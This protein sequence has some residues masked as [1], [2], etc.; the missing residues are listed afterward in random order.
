MYRYNV[1]IV[2]IALLMLFGLV[3]YS[4]A[5]GSSTN[6]EVVVYSVKKVEFDWL[7]DAAG[8]A[9]ST[10]TEYYT[11]FIQRVVFVP[12]AGGTQPT[13]LYDVVINDS[14]GEDVLIANGANLSNA[15]TV[16]KDNTTDGLGAVVASA[17][18]LGVTNAGNAKGGKVIIYLR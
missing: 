15:A 7:S 10:S 16:Q 13:N 1:E 3:V 8:A 14:D 6:T 12:D 9:D 11:G 2:F 5:A 17:L 18:T 4:F